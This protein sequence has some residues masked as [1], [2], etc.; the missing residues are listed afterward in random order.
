MICLPFVKC[1]IIQQVFKIRDGF[2]KTRNTE[3]E[4]NTISQYKLT[5]VDD[6]VHLKVSTFGLVLYK[7]KWRAFAFT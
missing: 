7:L 3:T 2:D 1:I 6:E 5:T 4:R